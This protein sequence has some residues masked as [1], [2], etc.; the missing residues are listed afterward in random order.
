MRI[1][2][3]N[4]K[5]GNKIYDFSELEDGVLLEDTIDALESKN[6]T[7]R[8]WIKHDSNLTSNSDLSYHGIMKVVEEDRSVAVTQ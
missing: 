6:I 8:L 3:K 7:I 5:N 1:S 4:G 2:V